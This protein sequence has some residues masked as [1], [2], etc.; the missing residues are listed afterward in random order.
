MSYPS[1]KAVGARGI[2]LVT[3]SPLNQES[4]IPTDA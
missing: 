3:D 4:R 1:L 2:S